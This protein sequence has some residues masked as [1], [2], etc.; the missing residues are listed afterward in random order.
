M[1]KNKNKKKTEFSCTDKA[2]NSGR[3]ILQN[4]KIEWSYLSKYYFK[5]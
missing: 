4:C 5:D 3:N 2:T 1:K